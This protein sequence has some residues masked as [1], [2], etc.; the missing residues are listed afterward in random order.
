MASG[1]QGLSGVW[2]VN[3]PLMR[4]ERVLSN[5]EEEAEEGSGAVNRPSS[6]A[7][8]APAQYGRSDDPAQPEPLTLAM[9][10]LL[11][12]RLFYYNPNRPYVWTLF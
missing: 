12:Q 8:P 4:E 11:A 2:L 9:S 7:Q 6:E 3:Y 5:S 1:G 10:F